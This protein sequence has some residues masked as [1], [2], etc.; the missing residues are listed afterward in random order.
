MDLLQRSDGDMGIDLRRL[1]VHV[2]K[3]LL[4]KA[5]V[6]SVLVHQRGHRVAEEMAGPGLSQLRRVDP[7][8]DVRGHVVEAER[9]ALCCEEHGHI[10]RLGGK[11]GAGFADVFSSHA[12]ARSP[13]GT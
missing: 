1:Q 11:L 9:L 5:D 12:M 8:L 13:M 6:G 7:R 2:S 10:V 3:Y 4:D